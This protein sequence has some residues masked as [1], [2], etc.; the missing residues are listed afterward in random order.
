[1]SD[2]L[3]SV[4]SRHFPKNLD[5]IF[6]EQPGLSPL[7]Y[8][9]L[10]ERSGQFANGLVGLGVKPGDRVAVQVEKSI[11]ALILYVATLRTGAIYLPLNPA[12]TISELRYFISDAEPVLVVCKPETRDGLQDVVSAL[13]GCRLETLT[14]SG[15]SLVEKAAACASEF[16]D[17]PR[18]AGDIAAI[19]YTSGT[20]GR[21]KGAMLT[22]GNLAS[23]VEALKSSWR[24]S[25]DDVLLHA[26]PIFHTHGLFV[27]INL[28][29]RSGSSMI[30]MPSFDA[31]TILKQMPKAT[32][33]MGVPTF[34]SRLLTKPELTRE[35][36]AEMRL[37]ISGS[38][39]LSAETHKEF[40]ARTG[41]EILERY[42]MTETNMNTS[43]PYEGPRIPGSVGPA[44]PGVE[45]R[46]TDLKSGAILG[47]GEAGGIEI[48][49]PNVFK[50]YWRMPEKT[51]EDFREDGF[52]K[53]GDV[54][55][56][57]ED[58]FVYIAGRSRDLIIT[59][60]LNV[61][62]AEVE[63]ALDAIPGVAE[64]AVIGVPH[65][66]FGEGVVAV[67]ARRNGA[68]LDEDIIRAALQDKLAKF[69]QPK[70]VFIVGDLPRNVM[71]KIQKN[72]L[73]DE[74]ARTFDA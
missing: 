13:P 63:A 47:R 20:T 64:S 62:P 73:R 15:G 66:D 4:L 24:F 40:S 44:L 42:G 33:M 46:I 18:A 38:A 19:L 43:N 16:S 51:K 9:G 29:L 65:A 67:V 48:R 72:M 60:G 74:F 27:A 36:T 49:G 2:N 21:S 10:V 3:F 31:D 11:E 5:Q 50:G 59:G 55:Y 12:Y 41:H 68:D 17:V 8:R 34:Y 58:G 37:F 25:A 35:A 71:G 52:F 61:Y 53:S 6:L 32:V 28:T 14:V 30:Y 70:K 26:L 57:D 69:K 1:M 22:H 45:I 7:T 39:P 54:G 56:M 23:N